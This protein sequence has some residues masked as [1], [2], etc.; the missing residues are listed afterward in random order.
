M[1][2]A[3]TWHSNPQPT[4]AERRHNTRHAVRIEAILHARGASQ[5]TVID[6]LSLGG[7]GLERAIG[8]YANDHVEIELANGR[9]LPGTV[10]WCLIGACG[11]QFAEP[12][13]PGDPLFAA[14][15]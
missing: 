9:R 14:V 7:A 6:D 13:P 3:A 4:G 5:P 10:A 1:F 15:E 2:P 8:I 11:V 12:L